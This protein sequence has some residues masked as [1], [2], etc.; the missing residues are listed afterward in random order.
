M[1]LPDRTRLKLA[2]EGLTTPTD[3][4]D[5]PEKE[6]LEA[7]VLKC[8]K[9]AKIAG[10]LVNAPLREVLQYAIPARSEVRLNCARLIVKYYSSVGRVV[11]ADDM[12]WPVLKNFMEHWKAMKEKKSAPVGIPPKLLKE[13]AVHKWVEQFAQDLEEVYGAR[14]A[15]LTYLTRPDV[16]TPANTANAPREV[17]QP[18]ADAFASIQEEM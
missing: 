12:F 14:N 11:E 3:F 6:D 13:L 2:A 1:A 7:L 8:L 16:A 4:I 9:P 18:Y 10:N 17:D 5:F 15:P